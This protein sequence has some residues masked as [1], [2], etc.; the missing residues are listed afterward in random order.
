MYPKELQ[1]CADLQVADH[2]SSFQRAD[3]RSVHLENNVFLIEKF[4]LLRRKYLFRDD[5]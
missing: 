3:P 1:I 4:E 5:R 2:A